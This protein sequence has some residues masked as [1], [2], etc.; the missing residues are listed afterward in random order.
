MTVHSWKLN[1]D[2]RP[3]LQDVAEDLLRQF[4]NNLSSLCV[5][6]PNKRARLFF[7]RYLGEASGG[8]TV[9]APAYRTISE[10]VQELSGLT[11]SDKTQLIFEL[12]SVYKRITGTADN[13]DDFYYYGEMLLADFE[14]IDKSMVNAR[15]LFRNLSDQK[16][17]EGSF[18]YLSEN[19]LNAIRQF[20]NSFNTR[21]SF[22]RPEGI[23]EILGSAV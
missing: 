21:R 13:F 12:F 14:E 19:Q 17:I 22:K 11:L 3:F 1:P 10:L 8:K 15:D 16:S 5:V 7:S 9:W 2:I 18:D 20:W 23:S 4:G 6:F